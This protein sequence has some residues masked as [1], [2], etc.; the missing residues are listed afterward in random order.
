MK[1]SPMVI[2]SEASECDVALA[3]LSLHCGSPGAEQ[4]F[5]ELPIPVHHRSPLIFTGFA[6]VRG[7]PQSCRF[8]GSLALNVCSVSGHVPER[9]CPSFEFNTRR[10]EL[11]NKPICDAS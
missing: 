9:I 4:Q 7:A 8:D 5:V 1:S 2:N 6:C 10:T 3:S 11:A